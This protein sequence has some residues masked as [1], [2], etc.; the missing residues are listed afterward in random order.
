MPGIMQQ[1]VRKRPSHVMSEDEEHSD[2]S[3]QAS[4][5]SKRA[6]YNDRDASVEV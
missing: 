2:A 4:T 3:S 1:R 5:G 6:R